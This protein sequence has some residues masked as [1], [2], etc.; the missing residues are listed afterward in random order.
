MKKNLLLTLALSLSLSILP[1]CK[2][3]ITNA[4]LQKHKTEITFKY[5]KQNQKTN[6]IM[7]LEIDNEWV[8]KI[9][10][11]DEQGAVTST[12]YQTIKI[13]GLEEF[14]GE[15]WYHSFDKTILWVNTDVGL[16]TKN[17][18]CDCEKEFRA[19]YPANS[20]D[21]FLSMILDTNMNAV[22]NDGTKLIDIRAEYYKKVNSN[23][24][25]TTPAGEFKCYEY[26]DNYVIQSE[27]NNIQMVQYS[28]D[29]YSENIGLIKS[30]TYRNS[31]SN[32]SFNPKYITKTV[33][34][35]SYKLN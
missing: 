16:M 28:A 33:E 23:L 7:P 4:E 18:A 14:N 27:S 9:T 34:L 8:Y 26:K 25:I 21:E 22:V 10:N 6:V 5:V 32:Y 30:I 19:K 3:D 17:I 15:K 24:Q 35:I 13:D 31:E 1:S 29:Y 11:F 2:E 12:E 20:G